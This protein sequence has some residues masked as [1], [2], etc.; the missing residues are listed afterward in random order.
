M[1]WECLLNY[2]Q[3]PKENILVSRISIFDFTTDFHLSTVDLRLSFQTEYSLF[4][5]PYPI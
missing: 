4:Y 5:P 2:K 3:E 1:L